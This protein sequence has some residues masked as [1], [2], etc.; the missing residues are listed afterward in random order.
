VASWQPMAGSFHLG[1]SG[2]AY[3]EW[4]DGVFYPAGVRA[5]GR[6]PYYASVFNSVEINYTFRRFPS[7]Q[8]F[9][10]WRDQTP[11]SFRFTL[12]AS[13]KITH[14][15]RMQNPGPMVELFVERAALLGPRIGPVLFRVPDELPYDEEL[16]T[17][18]ADAL[19]AG[20]LAVME[21]REPSWRAARGLLEQ[22]GIAWCVTDM[23]KEASRP[24]ELPRP[25]GYLRLRRESYDDAELGAWGERITEALGAGRDVY[26]YFRHEDAAAGPRMALR[27]REL[28]GA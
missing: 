10:K 26:C 22:R 20:L 14:V 9:E 24:E 4:L 27:L 6:L 3:D 15:G 25:F 5:A 8:L 2:F 1:T 12:K 28:L 13:A 17:A 21:C 16:L 23:D 18:F 7:A 19:P 11:E